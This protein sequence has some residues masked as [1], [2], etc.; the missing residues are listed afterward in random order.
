MSMGSQAMK[1]LVRREMLITKAVSER[2]LGREDLVDYDS[3]DFSGRFDGDAGCVQ[4]G[5][6]RFRSFAAHDLRE[7]SCESHTAAR[8][9]IRG[10]LLGLRIT[11]PLGCKQGLST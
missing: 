1:I 3:E 10:S 2:L 7:D 11:Q 8:K 5:D 4:N 6:R 9:L